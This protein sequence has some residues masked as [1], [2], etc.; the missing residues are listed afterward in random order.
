MKTPW[1]IGGGGLLLALALLWPGVGLCGDYVLI[2]LNDAMPVISE[3]KAKMLYLGKLRS[4]DAFGKVDLVDWPEGSPEK[5]TFY[6]SF[7]NK[8]IPQ[9]NSRRARLAFSGKGQPPDAIREASAEAILQWLSENPRG[10]AYVERQQ[11]PQGARIILD[12]EQGVGR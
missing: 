4:I 9:I 1:T 6:K 10:I 2:T 5:Q 7:L 3:S 11:V 8:S 12:I